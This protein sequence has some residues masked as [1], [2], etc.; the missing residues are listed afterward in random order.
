MHLEIRTS[1][2]SADSIQLQECNYYPQD[3]I[4][5]YVYAIENARKEY[6]MSIT[7]ILCMRRGKTK[8]EHVMASHSLEW[9][10][11]YKAALDLAGKER[12]NHAKDFAYI[13]RIAKSQTVPTTCHCGEDVHE[14][15]IRQ[16][17][18]DCDSD[19]LSQITSIRRNGEVSQLILQQRKPLEMLLTPNIHLGA[20]IHPDWSEKPVPIRS[21]EEHPFLFLHEDGHILTVNSDNPILMNTTLTRE[22]RILRVVY[23]FSNAQILQIV[24]NAVDASFTSIQRKEEMHMQLDEY[25]TS[26]LAA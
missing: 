6:G 25:W 26:H 3:E 24:R 4:E 15:S 21:Y 2:K 16:A 1:L 9:A 23:G 22:L 11:T 5:A 18:L 14:G 7:L 19:R 13:Y 8:Q 12:G 10:N 20:L 17:V